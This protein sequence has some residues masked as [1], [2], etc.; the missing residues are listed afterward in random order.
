LIHGFKIIVKLYTTLLPVLIRGFFT[1]PEEH[2]ILCKLSQIRRERWEKKVPQPSV[3]ILRDA[4]GF[5]VTAWE[6]SKLSPRIE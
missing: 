3:P 4:E 2:D 6:F 1:P 5:K